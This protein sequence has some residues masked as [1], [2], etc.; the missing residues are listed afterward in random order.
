M[1]RVVV[2]IPTLNEEVHIARAVKSGL[3]LGRVVVVDSGSTDRTKEIA[4]WMGAEIIEHDWEG[5]SAQKNWALSQVP[6]AADWVFFLDA[7]EW[8]TE[9]LDREVR[10]HLA[11]NVDGFHI[12]RR[13]VFEG[14]VL[15]HAWWY[16]DYQLRLFRPTR[17]HFED[18]LVHE[19]VIVAGPTG[20]LKCSLMHENLKGLDAFV[21]RHARYADLEAREILKTRSGGSA[22]QRDGRLLGSWPERRRFLKT[23]VWYQ[24]PLRPAIRFAW[25]YLVKRGFLD[26]REG[27]IY[28]QLIAAYEAMIDARL[29]ELERATRPDRVANQTATA[30]RA[31]PVLVCPRCRVPLDAVTPP[32]HCHNCGAA[33]GYENGV[34]ILVGD[35]SATAHDE[36]DHQGAHGHKAAQVAH[37]DRSV[38]EAFEI[39]RPRGTPRL[40]R[41]LLGEKFRRVVGPIRPHVVGVTALTVCG[42]SGMDAEFL[43]RAGAMVTSSDISLGA[44]LRAKVRSER[45]R[46]EIRSIVA[47]V[48]HLPFAD[49]AVDMVAVH[50]GLHHLHDPYAG[51]SEMARVARHWVVVT[52]PARASLTRLAIRLGLA[53]ETEDAG[54]RV[55]R[56]D[57]AEVATYL[58]AR[59]FVVLRAERYAMYY[60]HRPGVVFSLL[61]GPVIYPAVR[62]CWR[63]ANALVGRFGNKMVVVAKRAEPGE[64]SR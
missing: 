35:S 60:R 19:H 54:N 23:H 3:R 1:T 16:P 22:G 28:C 9:S 40:Y 12:P 30:H 2:V 29:L 34:A 18:R 6:G 21:A 31:W 59:G 64:E 50:D 20:Y 56:M 44:A 48:E 32:I 57:P 5:Y 41:F 8:I 36:P 4:A 10:E 47:D 39:D 62:V 33:Y 42:G 27:L 55:V 24:L 14:R 11:A 58:K 17:G 26:G 37:F 46:V 52:E 63:L 25:M 7:D 13:N 51:L 43:A 49:L 45:H 15:R 38:E 53:L 61:S